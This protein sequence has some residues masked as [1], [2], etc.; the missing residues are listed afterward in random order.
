MCIE[1]TTKTYLPTQTETYVQDYYIL[2]KIKHLPLPVYTTNASD[3]FA[4]ENTHEWFPLHATLINYLYVL[5]NVNLR[6]RN[7]LQVW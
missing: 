5:A 7:L 2:T 1:L 6:R 4:S 3:L